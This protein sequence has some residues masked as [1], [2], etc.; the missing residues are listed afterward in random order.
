MKLSLPKYSSKEVLRTKLL[1]AIA[2]AP[3]M[4]ADVRLATGEGYEGLR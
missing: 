1:L 3:T 2:H 4:D